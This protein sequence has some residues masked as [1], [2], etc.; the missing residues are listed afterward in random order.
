[1]LGRFLDVGRRRMLQT[2]TAVRTWPFKAAEFV[3]HLAALDL[4]IV[5]PRSGWLE[6]DQQEEPRSSSL[7]SAQCCVISRFVSWALAAR[8]SVVWAVLAEGHGRI[9]GFGLGLMNRVCECGVG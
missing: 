7:S 9:L 3:S 5:Q 1:M 8:V 6:L 2:E 4:W